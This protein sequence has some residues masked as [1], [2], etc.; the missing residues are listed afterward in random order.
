MSW[1]RRNLITFTYILKWLVTIETLNLIHNNNNNNNNNIII[2]IIGETERNSNYNSKLE[3]QFCAMCSNYLF[4]KSFI[5]L[6][7]E[8]NV[9]SHYKYSFKWVMKYKNQKV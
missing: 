8:S 6:I 9:G 3:F 5:Y 7:L 1:C 4:L 2:I